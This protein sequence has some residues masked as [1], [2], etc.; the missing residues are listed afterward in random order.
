[1]TELLSCSLAW[2]GQPC[3]GPA[4]GEQVQ[5]ASYHA[6]APTRTGTLCVR[7]CP[8]IHMASCLPASVALCVCMPA[9]VAL[10]G[11]APVALC[12]ITPL[13]NGCRHTHTVPARVGVTDGTHSHMR[14]RIHDTVCACILRASRSG[15]L[16]SAFLAQARTQGSTLPLAFS[17][18]PCPQGTQ[19][20]TLPSAQYLAPRTQGSTLPL[21]IASSPAPAVEHA[22]MP[23]LRLSQAHPPATA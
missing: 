14:A 21:P 15:C 5:Q 8:Y 7:V 16:L 4:L 11:P 3:L 19:G 22:G 23:L 9:S 2:P 18:V 20:S 6:V 17:T 13:P 12:H 10:R 1:M